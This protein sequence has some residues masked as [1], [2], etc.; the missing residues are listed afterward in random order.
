MSDIAPPDGARQP[1]LLCYDGSP[2]AARA[3]EV[4]GALFPGRAAIVLYVPAPVAVERIRTTPIVAVREEL[5]E[6]VRAA[7]RREAAA[8]AQEGADLARDAG[9]DATPLVIEADEGP[10]GVILRVAVEGRAAAV[11]VGRP[12]RPRRVLRSGTV[13]RSIVDRCPLPVVII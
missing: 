9:L 5:V 6:E 7:T 13:L 3:V 8:L 2:E 11:V 1:I 4:A 12:T 10:V